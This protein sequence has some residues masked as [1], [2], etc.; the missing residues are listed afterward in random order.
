VVGHGAQPRRAYAAPLAGAATDNSEV[1]AM[2]PSAGAGAPVQNSYIQWLKYAAIAMALALFLAPCFAVLSTMDRD[3]KNID[4]FLWALVWISGLCN[5]VVMGYHLLV[6]AH[7]KFVMLTWRFWVLRLHVGAGLVE[8]IAAIV[9][10]TARSPI[11]A[12]VV[13]V[14]ALV[15]HAPTAILQA[16]IAFGARAVIWP[17]YVF[18]SVLHGFCAVMLLLHP[19]SPFW[20]V[21]T[22]LVFNVYV[23]C[24]IYLFLIDW[25]GLFRADKY[26]IAILLAGLTIVPAVL[27]P[28]TLLLFGGFIAVFAL[29]YRWLFI[30]TPGE[31]EAFI[32]E[33]ARDSAISQGVVD[34]WETGGGEQDARRR[35]RQF[36]DNLD[37]DED[38]V[39]QKNEAA[40]ALAAWGLPD[41]VVTA[42]FR[43]YGGDGSLD[44][45]HFYKQVWSIGAVRERAAI[46]AEARAASSELDR[47]GCVFRRLDLEGNGSLTAYDLQLLLMEW[48][49][50]STEVGR[51]FERFDVDGD[52]KITFEEFFHKMRPVW[53][54]IF[55]QILQA[56]G[57]DRGDMVRREWA[58]FRDAR[59]TDAVKQVVKHD[60]LTRVRFLQN[61]DEGL[62][63]DLAS[64]LNLETFAA[65]AVIIAEGEP[66][67]KFY[68]ISAGMV[69]ISVGGAMIADLSTGGYFGEGS[70]LTDAPRSAT[71]TAVQ[72]CMLYAMTRTSFGFILAQYPAIKAELEALR[73]LRSQVAELEAL[74]N[75]HIQDPAK[76]TVPQQLLDKVSFLRSADRRLIDDLAG[77]LA[78]TGFRS[79][80]TIFQEGTPGDC[81]YLI[82]A[83]VVTISTG[84]ETVALLGAGASFGEGA[85]LHDAPRSATAKALE[86]TRAFT[87]NCEAFDLSLAKYP[88]ARDAIIG[89][90]RGRR[91]P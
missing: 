75:L 63:A 19:A 42:F 1:L 80:E 27:G 70:L 52:G 73:N 41:D 22:F 62:I 33:K 71:A 53:R 55:Y 78:E 44:F 47:A 86:D 24:R 9:A 39:L 20:L 4:P 74:R 38:G 65:G 21:N 14:A 48:G 2:Q 16:P 12:V 88:E 90:D 36:F 18:G 81:F 7:P 25:S 66:G 60:L 61:V 91:A 51:Y 77:A 35:A 79:G 26:T 17:T 45:E 30:R 10:L 72:D 54:F 23:W 68:L 6:P 76:R 69:R 3:W 58:A 59:R 28:L 67:D 64:S 13:A 87:L 46:A 43:K 56:E 29:L 57:A 37:D 85:L 32:R 84:G 11:A 31:W 89:L 15:F 8:L 40:G 49:L 82:A 83:G 5:V 34:V 50:P